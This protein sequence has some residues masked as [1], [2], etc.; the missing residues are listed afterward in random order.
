M[1]IFIFQTGRGIC[2]CRNSW[3]I[4]GIVYCDSDFVASLADLAFAGVG[5]DDL[6]REGFFLMLVLAGIA[7]LGGL[8][9]MMMNYVLRV[10]LLNRVRPMLMEKVL[11]LPLNY[12]NT[13]SSGDLLS[14][15]SGIADNAASGVIRM[16]QPVFVIAQAL[17]LV[18]VMA[19]VSLPLTIGVLVLFFIFAII[20]IWFR[21]RQERLFGE[22]LK[23]RRGL[24]ATTGDI[25]QGY[26]E[27]K[28]NALEEIFSIIHTYHQTW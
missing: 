17:Y 19:I 24:T 6:L 21:R 7:A 3:S 23:T 8:R 14:V 5:F 22:M 18:G 10:R 20:A 25:Y 13:R 1:S 16:V 9:G 26:E 4:D 27:N 2:S 28:Q 11:S 12:F 15:V